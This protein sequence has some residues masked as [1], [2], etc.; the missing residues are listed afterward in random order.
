M[1]ALLIESKATPARLTDVDADSL[2]QGPVELDVLY[3]SLNYKDGLALTGRGIARTWPLIPGI[4]VIGRV[5]RSQS[6]DWHRGDTVI[7]NG[8][9]S[10]ESTHGG[11][12]DRARVAPE[13]LVRLPDTLTAHQAASIGT[14]GFEAAIAV[15]K[16]ID[17]GIK[18]G[19]G[20]VLVTGAVGGVGS[21][22][23]ALLTRQ[24]YQVVAAT[25]RGEQ[26]ADYLHTL[27]VSR[28]INRQPLAYEAGA[29]LQKQHWTAAVDVAGGTTLGNVLAQTRYGGLVVACG[30]AQSIELATTVFPFILRDVTL[31]GADTVNAPLTTRIRAWDLLAT[32]LDLS[33]LE[34]M[35]R[36]IELDQVMEQ[37]QAIL[38]GQVRGRTTV[39]L[40]A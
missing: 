14:A 29:P 15:Q 12:A 27:G 38:G 11:Y 18:P 37:A 9:G 10:G 1:R 4:D 6:P 36:T 7:L 28:V 5:Q 24:G 35:T 8:A 19:D 25:G 30:M 32:T 17:A 2:L 39:R 31:A 3:S 40:T 16:I 20:E 23:C 33:L 13:F 22:A 21:V 26:E 34:S